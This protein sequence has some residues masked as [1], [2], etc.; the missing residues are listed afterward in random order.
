[1]AKGKAMGVSA[2]KQAA[3]AMATEIGIWPPTGNNTFSPQ[4]GSDSSGDKNRDLAP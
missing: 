2:P 4:M 1:M 3:M